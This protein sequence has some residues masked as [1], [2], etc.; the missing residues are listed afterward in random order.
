M[1]FLEKSTFLSVPGTGPPSLGC[2]AI[3]LAVILLS[4]PGTRFVIVTSLN[5]LNVPRPPLGS[6]DVGSF[7]TEGVLVHVRQPSLC[8]VSRIFN[9]FLRLHYLE[10]FGTYWLKD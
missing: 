7:P 2:P 9:A 1:G 8:L 3:S 6:G 4:Y 10:D 5:V